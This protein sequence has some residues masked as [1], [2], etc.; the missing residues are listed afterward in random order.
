MTLPMEPEV[1]VCPVCQTVNHPDRL[2]STHAFGSPSLD[3]RPPPDEG[4]CLEYMI[5]SCSHCNYVARTLD[6]TPLK[7]TAVAMASPSWSALMARQDISELCSDFKRGELIRRQSQD[8]KGAVWMAFRAVWVSDD[9]TPPASASLRRE[10]AELL[11]NAM[12]SGTPYVDAPGGNESLIADLYRRAT[13]WSD[14]SSWAEEGLEIAEDP[15]I[16]AVLAFELK[17]INAQD[18]RHYL[19]EDALPE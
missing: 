9:V 12:A 4:Y 8:L 13:D 18:D 14:A 19:I 17:L 7:G 5:E 16:G 11:K 6:S 3:L 1:V 2:R 15:V 10:A